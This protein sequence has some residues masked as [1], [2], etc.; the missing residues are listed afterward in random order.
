VGDAVNPFV[1]LTQG[2]HEL[3]LTIGVAINE[4]RYVFSYIRDQITSIAKEIFGRVLNIMIP[5]KK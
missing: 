4:I 5:F 3:Y 2:L 1:F